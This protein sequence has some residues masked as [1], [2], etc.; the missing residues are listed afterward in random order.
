MLGEHGLRPKPPI[1]EG[2]SSTQKIKGFR[3]KSY[4]LKIPGFITDEEIKTGI[5]WITPGW[6]SQIWS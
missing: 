1:L 4:W 5:S 3:F 2:D 6:I